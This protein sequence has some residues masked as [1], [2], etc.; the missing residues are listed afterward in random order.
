MSEMACL[1]GCGEK[2][3]TRGLCACCYSTARCRVNSK[4]TTWKEL[5]AL[6]LI[7]PSTRGATNKP[8][9]E[10][11]EAKRAKKDEASP[12][13]DQ[14]APEQP[15]AEEAPVTAVPWER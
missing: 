6:G 10:A 2:A 9:D 12:A 1:T 11:L 7:L 13:E 8:L 14:A 3:K 5:E 15:E 4:L